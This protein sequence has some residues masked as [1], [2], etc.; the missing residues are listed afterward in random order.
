MNTKVSYQNTNIN[1]TSTANTSFA[2]QVQSNKS[3]QI[4]G[5]TK[6]EVIHGEVVDLKNNEVSVIM[7]DGREV[8]GRLVEANTLSIGDKVSF[9]VEDVTAKQLSLKILS[10]SIHYVKDTTIDKALEA[11]N[12]TKNLRNRSIILS[13]LKQQMPIDK[14]TI[15]KLIQQSSQHKTATLDTLVLLNKYNIPLT[16]GNVSRLESFLHSNQNFMN[17]LSNLTDSVVELITNP[18]DVT[19]NHVVNQDIRNQIF[20]LIMKEQ[21]SA[22]ISLEK[23]PLNREEL[24]LV[25]DF[26]TRYSTNINNPNQLDGILETNITSGKDLVDVLPTLAET[27]SSNPPYGLE[28]H[29]G[30]KILDAFLKS[31]DIS[32]NKPITNSLT[33]NSLLNDNGREQLLLAMKD[34]PLSQ[35]LSNK[36]LT[37]TIT[38]KEL[39]QFIYKETLSQSMDN[40]NSLFETKEFKNILKAHLEDM[41]TLKPQD[42]SDGNKL[43]KHLQSLMDHT[44][45]IKESLQ[46]ISKDS[47]LPAMQHAAT[48][49]DNL[50]FIQHMSQLYHYIPIPLKLKE[51]LT[52]GEL[53][54]YKNKKSTT[55][56][57]EGVKVLLH[58]DMEYLGSTDIFVELKNQN[59]NCNFY[60]TQAD[61]VEF[62]SP[63]I[64]ELEETIERLGFTV[65]TSLSTRETKINPM[66]D[67]LINESESSNVERYNFDIR[68]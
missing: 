24:N 26:L 30:Y 7:N 44:N 37:G 4:N 11:A 58:L 23:M 16:D 65:Q 18:K 5:F 40:N 54:V 57:L 20:S 61:T 50:N 51:Q 1:N 34:Y 67:F 41:W 39:L 47:A 63:Y 3:N 31:A 53:F 13:L 25:K 38:T 64:K 35:E 43:D 68:A 55:D 48:V 2:S 66:E 33:I 42:L 14:N 12:L 45:A 62:I 6:G 60:F 32:S 46:N 19:Q 59:I 15:L 36:I 49:H 22:D 9:L 10:E 8:T 52:N 29:E 17:D 28:A 27:L 56:P 21:V